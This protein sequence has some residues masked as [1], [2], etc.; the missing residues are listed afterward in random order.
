MPRFYV[1]HELFAGME[2]ALDNRQMHHTVHVLRLGI[3]D[4][5]ML[6]NERSGEWLCKI[7]AGKK[8][9]VKCMHRIREAEEENG[10]IL[11]VSLINPAKMSLLLEKTTELGVAEIIP[12]I[13]QYTQFRKFNLEKARSIVVGASEQS[14][15]MTIPFLRD[16][17]D[18]KNLVQE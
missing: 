13:S 11:V 3:N 17:L 2:V 14:R 10:P 4:D 5:L 8:S 1:V 16:P 9:L 12:V 6:F 18:L 15:R 7:I